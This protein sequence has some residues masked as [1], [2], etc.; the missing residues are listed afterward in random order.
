[1]G[2]KIPQ[3]IKNHKLLDDSSI[4]E[5]NGGEHLLKFFDNGYGVSIV[6]HDGSYGLEM[7]VLLGNDEEW[8][9]TYDTPITSDVIGYMT[10]EECINHVKS[11]TELE[12]VSI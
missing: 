1:M 11:V 3:E 2:L 5:L 12:Q 7:A 8:D 9:L 10:P 4:T 6:R